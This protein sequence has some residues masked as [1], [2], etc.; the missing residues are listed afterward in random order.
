MD[1]VSKA[2]KA[3]I[4]Q[5]AVGPPHWHDGTCSC[6]DDMGICCQ[7]I[8]CN[9]CTASNIINKLETEMSMFSCFNC[10]VYSAAIY[11]SGSRYPFWLAQ[12]WRRELIQRYGI[13]NETGCNSC[14]VGQCCLPCVFCQVQRE[15]GKRM[16]HPGGCCADPP[17][18]QPGMGNM[19][20]KVADG[21]LD[22]R[23]IRRWGSGICQCT[24][25]ECI[26]GT[27]CPCFVVG[28]M[29]NFLD[30][31]RVGGVTP[32]A[33]DGATCCGFLCN[34]DGFLY[35]SRREVVERYGIQLESHVLSG[36]L[37]LCCPICSLLQ[38]RREMGYSGEW[39]G[40]LCQKE[41]PPRRQQ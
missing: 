3:E 27:C 14:L 25:S 41:A 26:E 32:G 12:A 39:P 38:T 6:F 13:Q 2:I 7:T 36:C 30:S 29:Y 28:Y 31:Q 4:K 19:L 34:P 20:L 21:V 33:M 37:T 5:R 16:E 23:S 24:G 40:G 8:W 17:P 22:G 18:Q 10:F 1:T 11:Y 9:P 15:M 35:S